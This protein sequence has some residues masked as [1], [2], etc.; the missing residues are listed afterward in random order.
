MQPRGDIEDASAFY[1]E[2]LR[3]YRLLFGQTKGSYKAFKKL[4]SRS[5]QSRDPLT[6]PL[7]DILYGKS[8]KSHE[9]RSIFDEIKANEASTTYSPS[10]DFPFL[11]ARLLEL[12]KYAQGQKQKPL[13]VWQDRRMRNP[14]RWN[15]FWW[16]PFLVRQPIY[17]THEQAAKYSIPELPL[18]VARHRI[19]NHIYGYSGK[20]NSFVI[21]TEEA[22]N[23][24]TDR[25]YCFANIASCSCQWRC[26]P[27]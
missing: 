17:S 19:N 7:L 22:D 25:S 21:E 14:F 10:S 27:G 26:G 2:V 8:C 3:S 5:S 15:Q 13:W 9:F 11:G 23:D 20:L 4:N 1:K 16:Y 12:Q 24:T 18:C 6:D